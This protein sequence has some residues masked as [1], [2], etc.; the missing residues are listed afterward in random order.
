MMD[1]QDIDMV[2]CVG[3]DGTLLHTSVLFETFPVPP[4]LAFSCGSLGFLMPFEPK[5]YKEVI[6]TALAGEFGVLERNR[7][8]FRVRKADGTDTDVSSFPP[9]LSLSFSLSAGPRWS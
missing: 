7:L 6:D 9:S 2:V 3:G 8:A 4:V 5:D 1:G